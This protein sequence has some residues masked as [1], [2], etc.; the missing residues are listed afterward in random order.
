MEEFDISSFRTSAL[1]VREEDIHA[2]SAVSSIDGE[3]AISNNPVYSN[4]LCNDGIHL[5][6]SLVTYILYKA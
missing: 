3:F 4:V 6:Q 5:A 1:D 2:G